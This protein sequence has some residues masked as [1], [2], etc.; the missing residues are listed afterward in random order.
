MERMLSYGTTIAA[1]TTMLV[2]ADGAHAGSV[3]GG[4]RGPSPSGNLQGGKG[5]GCIGAAC[6][7]KGPTP[8]GNKMHCYTVGP[9]PGRGGHAFT[10]CQ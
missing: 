1:I 4:V 3:A 6:S 8:S 10:Q 9:Q 2:L 7:V 5:G